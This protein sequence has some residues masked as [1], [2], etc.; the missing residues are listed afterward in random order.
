[1][2]L[3]TICERSVDGRGIWWAHVGHNWS[4]FNSK[5][6]TETL[7]LF[8]GTSAIDNIPLRKH[9]RFLPAG[10]RYTSRKSR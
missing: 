2:S 7:F 9:F 6:D 10:A 1:M 5:R 8:L 3:G 4:V